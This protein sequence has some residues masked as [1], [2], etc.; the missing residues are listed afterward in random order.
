MIW[1]PAFCAGCVVPGFDH[2]TT[3]ILIGLF[4][5]GCAFGSL[6]GGWLGDR[7]AGVWPNGGRILCAQFSATMGIPF[8]F[9]LLLCLPLDKSAGVW[10]GLTFLCGGLMLSWSQACANNPI[11][12]EIVP[13]NMRTTIYAFDRA[14]EGG[15][16]ALAAPA[17]GYMAEHWYGYRADMVIPPEGSPR[18][19]RAIGHGLF[20]CMAIPW[21][22]CALCY[23]TLYYTY[24]KDRHKALAKEDVTS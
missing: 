10:F 8:S 5:T 14:F 16:S 21:G 22:L 6:F 15:I 23:G 18:E 4:S 1:N 7:A 3:A 11:F 24:S 9:V 17:V 2:K 20:L 19:A 12:S 13:A